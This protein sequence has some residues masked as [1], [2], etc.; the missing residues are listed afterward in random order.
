M[1]YPVVMNHRSVIVVL[2][3]AWLISVSAQSC[4][5]GVTRSTPVGFNA[6]QY[7]HY[8]NGTALNI[9][10][11]YDTCH[12][13]VDC[14]G[15]VYDT[16]QRT[17][18]PY[19][20]YFYRLFSSIHR[21]QVFWTS[22]S[23]LPEPGVGE[24][25]HLFD[26]ISS[27]P[28]PDGLFLDVFW[29]Y[30]STTETLYDGHVRDRSEVRDDIETDY[31]PFRGGP[32]GV[33]CCWSAFNGTNQCPDD[34]TSA[35]QLSAQFNSSVISHWRNR[36]HM[37]RFSPNA[38]CQLSPTIY[39]A[40]QNCA[41]H[42]DGCFFGSTEVCDSST[43]PVCS[44]RGYCLPTHEDQPS[45]Y[46][47]E[48]LDFY[49]SCFVGEEPVLFG[50]NG[51][52]Y[53]GY[54]CDVDKLD[55]TQ[56]GAGVG[57]HVG[58][59]VCFNNAT[60]C[61]VTQETTSSCTAYPDDG[62]DDFQLDASCD[63]SHSKF[64]TFGCF[65][66][67]ANMRTECSAN[68]T[69]ECSGHGSCCSIYNNGES[70]CTSDFS[71]SWSCHC[72]NEDNHSY[73]GNHCEVSDATC[74]SN[75][76]TLCNA[77]GSPFINSTTDGCQCLCDEGFGGHLCECLAGCN[78]TLVY[79]GETNRAHCLCDGQWECRTAYAS[80][81]PSFDLCDIDRCGIYGNPSGSGTSCSCDDGYSQLNLTF[82]EGDD[83]QCYRNCPDDCGID[84]DAATLNSSLICNCNCLHSYSVTSEGSCE[85]YCLNGGTYTPDQDCNALPLRPSSR[86]FDPD[87]PDCVCQCPPGYEG[88]RCETVILECASDPCQNGGT[89]NE[90]NDYYECTCLEEF[91]GVHCETPVG[92]G[93]SSSS[94]TGGGG[95]GAPTG[96]PEDESSSSSTGV[97][98]SSSTGQ[99]HSSST[100][101]HH[102]SSSS[103]STARAITRTADDGDP[104]PG[105][106]VS[107]VAYGVGAIIVLGAAAY[108]IGG[109][110]ATSAVASGVATATKAGSAVAMVPRG[111]S[112]VR[113]GERR[114]RRQRRRRRGDESSSSSDDEADESSGDRLIVPERMRIDC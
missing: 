11:A 107:Y 9:D 39:D 97:H 28:C 87:S 45:Y 40:S 105:Q 67:G 82:S 81:N 94:S 69:I 22:S 55:T 41:V 110:G 52:R 63:C 6:S 5:C 89:C 73:I 112:P 66:N 25:V 90:G 42:Q 54:A 58:D 7:V 12:S 19:Q 35:S 34:P 13:D 77:R 56:C 53:T 106:V 50:T 93:G 101:V 51:A 114:V 27:Y 62:V 17:S 99:H 46:S 113:G 20:Y 92:G 47:D 95:T 10:Q 86:Q 60:Q 103:S 18:G 21:P 48:D 83:F 2:F 15:I 8:A 29:Y 71:A 70:P 111:S 79:N 104:T 98:P 57:E 78:T 88:D 14:D 37:S 36:G 96:P 1:D 80:S 23:D 76:T 72:V 31:C 33:E 49:C 84:P 65:F 100:S 3:M 43:Q 61:K 4:D 32:S 38:Y 75:A 16:V 109:M 44:G 64:D 102:S 26:R 74:R 91:E 24:V 68:G 108:W 59:E 85:S 30:F